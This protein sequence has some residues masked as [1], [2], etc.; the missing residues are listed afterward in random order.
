MQGKLMRRKEKRIVRDRSFRTITDPETWG[1]VDQ[2]ITNNKPPLYRKRGRQEGRH[3]PV[4]G[5]PASMET[6]IDYILL[7]QKEKAVKAERKKL[8]K[9]IPN[10]VFQKVRD[11][12][13]SGNSKSDHKA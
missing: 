1:L 10:E 8:R 4:I 2:Y 6:E 11:H 13:K 12:L 7:F 3:S 9:A 5:F